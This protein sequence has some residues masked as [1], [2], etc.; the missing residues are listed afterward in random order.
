MFSAGAR[1]WWRVEGRSMNQNLVTIKAS[2]LLGTGALSV[3]E[4]G[5]RWVKLD[6]S[7]IHL[8]SSATEAWHSLDRF[9]TDHQAARIE[10]LSRRLSQQ[11]REVA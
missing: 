4:Q 10:S 2:K 3:D 6:R 1:V 5:W 9:I 7:A 11:R 8:G